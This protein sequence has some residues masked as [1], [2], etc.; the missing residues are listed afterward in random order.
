MTSGPGETNR[1]RSSPIPLVCSPPRLPADS[2][3]KRRADALLPTGAAQWVF[4]AGVAAAVSVAR[5]L[6]L[7]PG[8]ALDLVATVAAAAWCLVNFWRCREAHCVV[9]GVGWTG[10]AA[11]EFVELALG[12]SVISGDEGI[13]FVAILVAALAFEAA[14]R[15]RHGTN[16][17]AI[18]GR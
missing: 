10:L 6:P 9:S 8:L 14:W 3:L 18:R 11:L 5:Y 17:V 2:R 4:F 15:V 16:A 12:R 1:P 13:A 7:R